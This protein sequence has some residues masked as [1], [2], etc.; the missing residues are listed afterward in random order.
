V[1]RRDDD[2]EQLRL[3]AEVESVRP[4]LDLAREIQAEVAR[5][6]G[7]D[8]ADAQ[9]LV[10]AIEAVPRRERERIA[11][12]V[13]DRLPPERQW[14]ILERAFGDAEIRDYLEQ[15]RSG[16]LAAIR[17]A[18]IDLSFAAAARTER[19]LDLVSLPAGLELTLGLFRAADVR[20]ALLRGRASDVCAR[21]LVLRTTD[22]AGWLHVIEDVFNPRRGLFVTADYDESVWQRER[23]E[24]HDVVRV[25]SID[26]RAGEEPGVLEPVLYPGGRVDVEVG[27]AVREGRLHLGFVLVG[28]ED[29]FATA[30]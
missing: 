3:A 24:S 28:E 25:G 20:A 12:A 8:G 1:G 30:T 2:A 13:F 11:R 9:S 10:E 14:A 29:T 15:D 26:A 7:D 6:A 21:R 23:L 5:V 27:G 22:R 16:R 17:R 4:F 18:A 19:R